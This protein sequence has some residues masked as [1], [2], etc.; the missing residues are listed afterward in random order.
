LIPSEWTKVGEVEVPPK[1][2]RVGFYAVDPRQSWVL[3]ASMSSQFAPLRRV[4]GYQLRLRSPER[5]H[6]AADARPGQPNPVP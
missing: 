5:M 6:A 2:E 3:R 1:R 4:E